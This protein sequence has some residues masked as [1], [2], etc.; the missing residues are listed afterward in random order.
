MKGQEGEF[1]DAAELSGLA[2][3]ADPAF[4]AHPSVSLVRAAYPADTIWR[5]IIADPRDTRSVC[6]LV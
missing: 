4:V 1:S 6:P 5:A 3:D 2:E